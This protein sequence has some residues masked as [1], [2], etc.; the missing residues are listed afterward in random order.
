M[1]H[2]R[3]P[4]FL[5]DAER[6]L[7]YVN[8][9]WEELTGYAADAVLGLDCRPCGP[10]RVGET[11]GL[12][13]SFGPPSEVLAGQPAGGP[14]LIVHA[15]GE[16]R[17]RRVE[18]WPYHDGKG[19]LLFVFGL[20]REREAPAHAPDAA[21]QRLRTELLEIRDRLLARHGFDTL[22]GRGAGHRRLL[23]QVRAAA[24]TTVPVLVVG[25]PGTGKRLVAR[26]IHQQ[27][28]HPQALFL[29][30][31]CAALPPEDLQRELFGIVGG[32]QTPRTALPQGSTVLL[33]DV[34]DLPRDLQNGLTSTLGAGVR[35]LATTTGDPERARRDDRLC[36]DLYY[37][38]TTLVIHLA[39]LRDRLDEL[40]LLV[41]H[42]MERANQRGE[43]RRSGFSPEAMDALIGYDWPGNLRELARVIDAAQVR[44]TAD[45]I[46]VDDLPAAIRGHLGSSYNPPPMP[47]AVVPLDDL[48]TQVER[49]VIEQALQRARHNKS[50][51]AELL[52]ISRPRL[53]RRI[54]ELNIP[55]EPEPADDVPTPLAPRP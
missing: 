29:S 14:I 31:D 18:F 52:D 40:P 11:A 35:L 20:V 37:A 48:L 5:L 27:G 43:R 16:R 38:L 17:W 24:A 23:D 53:Y 44:G 42:L 36:L 39:P 13:D 7:A 34:L 9:A 45:L 49:R 1:Q 51:A 21:S 12:G 41:Q 32:E 3:E 55:D 30:F 46:Q 50:R 33:R 4:V 2:A 8:P 22:I 19:T 47:P 54:K 15:Q 26:T 25:E 28:P 10:S 6:R